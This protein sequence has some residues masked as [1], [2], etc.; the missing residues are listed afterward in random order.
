M[1]AHE[2]WVQ[3][4]L[5]GVERVGQSFTKPDDDWSPV[6]LVEDLTGRQT[7]LDLREAFADEE[8]KER[9]ATTLPLLIVAARLHRVAMASS[10]WIV[11]LAPG[12]QEQARQHA[13][14]QPSQHPR[15]QEVV[16]VYACSDGME[17]LSIAAIIRNHKQPPRLGMWEKSIVQGQGATGI[18]GRLCEPIR[19][20]VEAVWCSTR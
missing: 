4:A 1:N 12:E 16:V 13:W 14:V 17:S 7:T 19:L 6:L 3:F 5:A 18:A 11:K 9:F 10:S 2:D 15:R 8:A 20:G